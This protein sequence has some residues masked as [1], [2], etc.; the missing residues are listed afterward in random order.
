MDLKQ[1]TDVELAEESLVAV[2]DYPANKERTTAISAEMKARGPDRMRAALAEI[3]ER[4]EAARLAG[5]CSVCG[6]CK[7][8]A[9][10]GG[11]CCAKALGA[12][13]VLP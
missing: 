4:R 10:Y 2:K 11:L 7:P 9:A 6:D 1:L 12:K 5:Q 8:V 13:E 3:G